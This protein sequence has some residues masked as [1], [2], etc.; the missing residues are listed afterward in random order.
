MNYNELNH[1]KQSIED[2]KLLI[3]EVLRG[4]K[5]TKD[6]KPSLGGMGV[7][8]QSDKGTFMVRVRV[9]AGVLQINE[10]QAIYEIAHLYGVKTVHLTSRQAVQFHGVTL[11][12]TSQ[13]MEKLLQQNLITVGSGGNKPRN[14]ACSPL[15]GVEQGEA[16]DV[17]PYALSSYEHMIKHLDQYNLPRKYKVSFSNTAED[18]ANATV[19][20]V[21]F[22][23][24][25][26]EGN[27]YFKVF[28]GGGLGRNP[29]T[30]TVLEDKIPACE[31]LYYIQGAKELFEDEGD[32]TNR[33][34]ARLRYVAERLGEEDFIKRLK[35]YVQKVKA[36]ENLLITQGIERVIAKKGKITK[37]V[38]RH[39]YPQNQEGL[40]SVYI[41]PKRGYIDV[42]NVEKILTYLKDIEQSELRLTMGQ[43]FYIINLNGEEA[44]AL[45]D[46]VEALNLDQS[47]LKM[48]VCTG[49]SVCQIGIGNTEALIDSIYKRFKR[50]SPKVQKALPHIHISGC[51]NSCGT[52]QI[53]E[54]GLC[55]K[56]AKIDGTVT[57]VYTVFEGG[58][59][60]FNH[61]VF[62]EPIKEVPA[63]DIPQ[64]LYEMAKIR[65]KNSI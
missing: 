24:F 19:A 7:Y 47:F 28:A 16:F 54:L 29:K 4:A 48:T 18:T 5:T 13:I 14:I 44:D 26:Q 58:K 22:I 21:G 32:R 15:S 43:G 56:K 25:T 3:N 6:I 57:D 62:G 1:I 53:S 33:N 50:I 46:K 37:T 9:P 51:L 27:K 30:A 49:S 34:K 65:S 20:D 63:Q 55:G 35:G 23:A 11:E 45:L 10:L 61:T 39:L 17:L 42:Q 8:E 52:H 60:G 41:H 40:Y 38:H 12:Q 2:Y 36:R 64:M 31:A 59:K